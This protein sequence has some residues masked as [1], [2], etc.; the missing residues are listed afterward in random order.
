MKRIYDDNFLNG[1]LTLVIEDREVVGKFRFYDEYM[2]DVFCLYATAKCHKS[3]NWS[4]NKGIE[5]VKSKIAREYHKMYRNQW[6]EIKRD[7]EAQLRYVTEEYEF[8]KR[9]VANIEKD[10]N[11]HYGLTYWT[12]TKKKKS[13]TKT[14]ATKKKSNK[15]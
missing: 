13:S 9:K 10:L 8:R 4:E 3:D 14:S 6:A 1:Q 15:K 2:D 5:L 11:E 12:R 7:L